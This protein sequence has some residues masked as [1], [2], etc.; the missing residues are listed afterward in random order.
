ML[1]SNEIKKWP[2]NT[3]FMEEI[4]AGTESIDEASVAAAG[5]TAKGLAALEYL[6]FAPADNAALH[7][8]LAN[9][10]QR[11]DYLVALAHNLASTS[12][13]LLHLWLP[14]GDA[15]ADALHRGCFER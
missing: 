14:S 11:M 15:H 1:V 5:S 4:I 10:P 9:S 13:E 12:R 3:G 6:L 8:A 7:S 2:I